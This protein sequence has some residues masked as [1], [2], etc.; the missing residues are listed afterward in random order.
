[1]NRD[2]CVLEEVTDQADIAR[3]RAQD[4]RHRRN[5]EWLA[6]HWNELLPQARGRFV[7][8]A[9]EEA[10]V[11]DTAEAAWSQARAAHP[12]DDGAFSQYVPEEGGPRIYGSHGIV[13]G[14]R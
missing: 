12:E 2:G 7:A 3:F 1:M 4:E 5:L 14:L 13:A 8:V 9:G 11:A 6:A 10:F